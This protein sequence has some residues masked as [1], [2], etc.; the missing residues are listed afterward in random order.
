MAAKTLKIVKASAAAKKLGAPSLPPPKPAQQRTSNVSG[1]HFDC[2]S[3][4]PQSKGRRSSEADWIADN[5]Y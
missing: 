5:G 4:L 2:G 1:K 3:E